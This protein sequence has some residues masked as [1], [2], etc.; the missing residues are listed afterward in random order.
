[1][2]KTKKVAQK[3]ELLWYEPTATWNLLVLH[4]KYKNVY[5]GKYMYLSS[6]KSQRRPIQNACI[7][8]LIK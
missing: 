6:N 7:I 8:Q 2:V 5:G 3:A 4:Y 1:M